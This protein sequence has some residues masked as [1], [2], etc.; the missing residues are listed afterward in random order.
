M[1]YG[2]GIGLGIAVRIYLY[3]VD[4]F[5]LLFRVGKLVTHPIKKDAFLFLQ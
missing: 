5:F 2:A 1:S 3:I 4:V